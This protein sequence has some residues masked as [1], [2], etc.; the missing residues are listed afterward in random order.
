MRCRARDFIRLQIPQIAPLYR[1]TAALTPVI[2]CVAAIG[3]IPGLI[4]DRAGARITVAATII[5]CGTIAIAG[6][7]A[8]KAQ[9]A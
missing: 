1:S 2:G 5:M 4:A 9:A 6:G 3:A 8:T 7:H